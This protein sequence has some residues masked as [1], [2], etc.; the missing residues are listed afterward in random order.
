MAPDPSPSTCKEPAD[1]DVPGEYGLVLVDHTADPRGWKLEEL[2]MPRPP[3]GGALVVF[4]AQQDLPEVL[5][6]FEAW[7]YEYANLVQ[8]KGRLAGTHVSPHSKSAQTTVSSP[9]A[10]PPSPRLP[11]KASR[12]EML[13]RLT[14]PHHCLCCSCHLRHSALALSRDVSTFSGW[15]CPS[16][17]SCA[18]TKYTV[19]CCRF[20]RSGMPVRMWSGRL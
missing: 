5:R 15:F 16:W 6:L 10:S 2:Q 13:N 4:L 18:T 14:P 12:T 3:H 11:R 20:W 19:L 8:L 1:V 9:L 7:G 17:V